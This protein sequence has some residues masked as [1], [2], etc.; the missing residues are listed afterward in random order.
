MKKLFLIIA[1]FVGLIMVVPSAFA[2]YYHYEINV[3][4]DEGFSTAAGGY[5]SQTADITYQVLTAGSTTESTLYSDDA[6]TGMT[7]PVTTTIFNTPDKIDFYVADTI[8]SVDIIIVDTDGGYTLF[9]DGATQYTRTAIIDETPNIMHHGCIWW[10]MTTSSVEQDTGVDLEVGSLVHNVIWEVITIASSNDKADIGPGVGGT[11]EDT[12]G[13]LDNIPC[14]TA[15]WFNPK[16]ADDAEMGLSSGTVIYLHAD[17]PL[18]A[19]IG[20]TIVGSG[21]TTECEGHR[22]FWDYYVSSDAQDDLAYV[23][24]SLGGSTGDG[25]IHWFFTPMRV[26]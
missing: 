24:P 21:G 15:G 7:N 13:F 2:G 6:G 20:T 10:Q 1:F 17:S 4:S 16:E 25:Y 19:L 9:L 11:G 23:F 5:T 18:G 3:Y 8:A 22:I 12:D 14:A 26:K